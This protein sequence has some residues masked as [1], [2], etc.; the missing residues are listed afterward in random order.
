MKEKY[1][2]PFRL[3]IALSIG[4]LVAASTNVLL[5]AQD[6]KVDAEAKRVLSK[7]YETY[8]T[9]RI[10]FDIEKNL[11]IV[12]QKEETSDKQEEKQQFTYSAAIE[13]P[14]KIFIKDTQEQNTIVSNGKTLNIHFPDMG[15]YVETE[16]PGNYE[17]LQSLLMEEPVSST[18]LMVFTEMTPI[19]DIYSAD[20]F[21]EALKNFTSVSLIGDEE[22]AGADCH[23][24]KLEA[25]KKDYYLWIEKGNQPIIRQAQIDHLKGVVE[26]AKSQ[27]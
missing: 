2:K 10:A 24:I 4:L 18:F 1:M 16:A 6:A 20:S 3:G 5:N 23:K 9:E 26:K 19:V 11:H 27:G 22:I 13:R 14:N 12:Y 15:V 25:Q 21:E 8:N 17:K 7:V